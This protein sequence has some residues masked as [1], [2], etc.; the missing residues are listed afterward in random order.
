MTKETVLKCGGYQGAASVHTRGLRALAAALAGRDDV[1]VELTENVTAQGRKAV[2][3]LA[4]VES[5]AL[6][7][8]YFASSYLGDRVPAL[9]AL[10]LPFAI[11][12]RAHAWRLLDGT[13]GAQLGEAIAGATGYRLLACWDNGFRHITNRVRPLRMP[14]DCAGLRIRTLDS[15]LHQ[16]IFRALGFDPV[17]IDVK[18]LAAAVASGAVDAQENPL[19]NTV[20]FGLHRYQPH[21]SLTAHFFGVALVLVNR[22]NAARWAAPV[23]DA[24]L[25][26][27][28]TATVAQ[29]R[30]AAAEDAECLAR[31]AADG[32]T[33]VGPDALDLAGFE[34]A[35]AP[36]RT[37]VLDGLDPAVA[38]AVAEPHP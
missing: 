34:R 30:F 31:L 24:I 21:V 13:L 16:E 26:A 35:I 27:V 19:T 29:R 25:D 6:D 18:D 32:C 5:G 28:S 14:A 22:D 37:R 11:R 12:D 7:L 15:A 20:N 23:R 8:C 38:A 4:M 33:V 10:D 1:T 3:L 17:A 2:D 36:I 9:Q